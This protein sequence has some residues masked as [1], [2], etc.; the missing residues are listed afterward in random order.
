[1]FNGTH[2]HVCTHTC[3]NTCTVTHTHTHTGAVLV[4]VL[5]GD[6][7]D[8]LGTSPFSN[9]PSKGSENDGGRGKQR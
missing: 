7:N 6:I 9:V 8:N 1:M 3:K 2:T 5:T 4:V